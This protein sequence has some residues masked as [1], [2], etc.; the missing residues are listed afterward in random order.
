MAATVFVERVRCVLL[1]AEGTLVDREE[2]TP[3]RRAEGVRG[4]AASLGSFALTVRG[5]RE[6]P[7]VRSELWKWLT[8]IRQHAQLLGLSQRAVML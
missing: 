2:T 8:S 1:A 6:T 5:V 3:G 7:S 4:E